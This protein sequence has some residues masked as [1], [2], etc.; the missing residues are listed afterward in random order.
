MKFFK[1]KKNEETPPAAE[2]K[3][4]APAKGPPKRYVETDAEGH[5]VGF[6][7]SDINKEIPPGATAITDEQ[8]HLF[9]NGK[10]RH[11]LIKGK[12]IVHDPAPAKDHSARNAKRGHRKNNI[13]N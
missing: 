5:P 3:K 2:N 4:E 11:R 1:S 12:M 6:Y 9:H 7:S 8:Y 10:V 13:P